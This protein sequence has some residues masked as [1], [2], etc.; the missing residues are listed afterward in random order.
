[1]RVRRLPALS[2]ALAA[3]LLAGP[4]TAAAQATRSGVGLNEVFADSE[5]EDYLRYLQ[6]GG[7]VPLYPW[8]VRSF[9]P[10]EVDRILP[11]TADHIWSAHYPLVADTTAGFRWNVVPPR[12][13]VIYNTG[14]PYGHND[15]AVWAG[16]GITTAIEG[17]VS[18]RYGPLSAVIAPLVFTSQNASFEES[19]VV[20]SGIDRPERF[21][22]GAYSRVDPGQSTIRIDL[23]IITAGVSTANEHWGPVGDLPLI[24][25]SNA[26][27]FLHG[28]LGTSEPLDLWAVK[29]HGRMV[30]GRLTASPWAA[31]PADSSHHLMSALVLSLTPRGVP[32]LEIGATRVFNTPWP[33]SGLS[34]DE[35]T[36]PLEG[37]L[38]KSVEVTGGT[39]DD[40]RD[41]QLIS[42]FA[43]WV[44]P[45][46]GFEV[47]G[48]YAREDY[49]YNQRDFI[50]E[51]DHTRGYSVGARKQWQREDGFLGLRAELLETR[52]SNLSRVRWQGFFYTHT[53]RVGHTNRGQI[54][55][56]EAGLGGQGS[57]VAL[58]RYSSQGRWTVSW[59]RM[60]RQ[61][62]ENFVD[63]AVEYD[64]D[65]MDVQHAVR[66]ERLLFGKRFDI[67][68]A[69]V[70]V[71]ELNRNFG[72]DA[73]NLG[74]EV[75]VRATF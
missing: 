58:D 48:E 61:T 68:P 55:G 60:L 8:T 14:F 10:R 12:A 30:W 7:S 37:L 15:G 53:N 32:G 24:L 74:A 38:K 51:L 64:G 18:A 26:P 27:G 2:T 31:T 50:V 1:M 49:N 5:L 17:G 65:A 16:R 63:R 25:G 44:A 22:D 41:D 69:L 28:F 3:L 9:S 59:E 43:R 33:G 45:K 54:L 20:W 56:S 36:R 11:T 21:G 47:Y 72:G 62:R 40:K 71:Y 6:I 35:L 57:I 19:G 67:A 75:Q 29:V 70:G 4:L 42:V 23:P 39:R 73:F 13:R 52:G 66:V 34:W 46:S